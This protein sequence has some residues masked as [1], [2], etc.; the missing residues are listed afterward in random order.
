MRSNRPAMPLAELH[1]FYEPAFLDRAKGDLWLRHRV[2]LRGQRRADKTP[3]RRL[4]RFGTPHVAHLAFKGEQFGQLIEPRR[5]LGQ[6]HWLSTDCATRRRG[7]GRACKAVR[8]V[9]EQ[10]SGLPEFRSARGWT[11]GTLAMHLGHAIWAMQF[12]GR[13]TERN[14]AGKL[15]LRGEAIN[16]W[17]CRAGRAQ[18]MPV[19]RRGLRAFQR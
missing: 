18:T 3:R 11:D 17:Q 9:H 5:S 4:G 16:L 12:G 19:Q 8:V 10:T 7:R 2:G 14:R 15:T 13:L 6:P 1:F